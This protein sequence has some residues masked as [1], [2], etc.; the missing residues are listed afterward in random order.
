MEKGDRISKSRPG[1]QGA[2]HL[3]SS[4]N[5][6]PQEPPFVAG[7]GWESSPPQASSTLQTPPEALTAQLI[8]LT[9][10]LSPT[11][12]VL[13][14]SRVREEQRDRVRSGRGGPSGDDRKGYGL[15]WEGDRG[16]GASRPSPS[17]GC[18][19]HLTFRWTP[20]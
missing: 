13:P 6:F 3:R 9:S 17:L 2:R 18:L 12:T 4:Y 8:P 14:F 15:D 7:Q 10:S 16:E 20:G 5:S 11:P 19:L 1:R